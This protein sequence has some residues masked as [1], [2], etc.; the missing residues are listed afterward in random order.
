MFEGHT[1]EIVVLNMNPSN[2]T[3]VSVSKNA[4]LKVFDLASEFSSPEAELTIAEAGYSLCA[5]FDNMGI[6]LAVSV[7][8]KEGDKG[9]NRID[10]FDVN[11][12]HDEEGSFASWR[13][14]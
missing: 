13:F 3:F 1:A 10:L 6:V 11:R 8:K 5:N 7:Y 4:E 12:F 9:M 2:D 14:D